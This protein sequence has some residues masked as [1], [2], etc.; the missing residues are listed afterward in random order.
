MGKGFGDLAGYFREFTESGI[1]S[2]AMSMLGIL[3]FGGMV[4]GLAVFSFLNDERK[5]KPC[6]WLSGLFYP[7]V[8]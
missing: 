7:Q 2:M 3:T 1:K 6:S 8:R 5:K 4:Y